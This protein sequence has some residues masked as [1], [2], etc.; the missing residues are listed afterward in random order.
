MTRETLHLLARRHLDKAGLG[1]F[2]DWAV[3]MLEEGYDTEHLRML[4]SLGPAPDLADVT[5]SFDQTI[6]EL[7]WI[8]APL[9]ILLR[10]YAQDIARNILEDTR[11]PL[12]GCHEIYAIYRDLG[13]P[14]D[15]KPWLYL[16]DGLE[17]TTCEEL[18]GENW[19]LAIRQE[20]WRF[21]QTVKL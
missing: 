11:P 1:D 16:D 14:D 15:M 13:Y 21:L 8:V 17:P 10:L 20:A 5:Y 2:V 3:F 6:H 19:N 18:E 12:D 7:N 4:A 9:P